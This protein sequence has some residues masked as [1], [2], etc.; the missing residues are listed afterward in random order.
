MLK[1]LLLL[2]FVMLVIV[3]LGW[4]RLHPE[5]VNIPENIT[6]QQAKPGLSPD[7][8]KN[9]GNVAFAWESD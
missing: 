8:M 5:S 6:L 7:A 9:Q 3:G 1:N 4:I 2:L